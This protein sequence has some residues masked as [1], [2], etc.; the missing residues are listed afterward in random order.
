MILVAALT[1]DLR[2]KS[3]T[4]GVDLHAIA[5][6]NMDQVARAMGDAGEKASMPHSFTT[7]AN[8]IDHLP[9]WRYRDGDVSVAYRGERAVWISLNLAGTDETAV[10]FTPES[11]LATLGLAPK[12]P[13]EYRKDLYMMWSDY[14]GFRQIWASA[15]SESRGAGFVTVTL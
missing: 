15:H 1:G 11:V 14:A 13:T 9:V 5:G 3:N 7:D 8:T 6:Q 4:V 10:P 12:E 2:G